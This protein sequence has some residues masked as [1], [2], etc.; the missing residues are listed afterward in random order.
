MPK[1][2]VAIDDRIWT[3]VARRLEGQGLSGH[4][5]DLLE[6]LIVA[7][8]TDETPKKHVGDTTISSTSIM[9]T[10]GKVRVTL[11]PE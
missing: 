9:L 10:L 7:A 11:I 8:F 6:A 4:P 3:K 1:F 5:A 2:H